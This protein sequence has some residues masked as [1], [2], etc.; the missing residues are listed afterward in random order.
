[1]S[2]LRTIILGAAVIAVLPTD[3]AKQERLQQTVA[4]AA[5]WS[6]T[7]CD[8]NAKTCEQAASTWETFKQKAQ[9]AGEVVIDLAMKQAL[10]AGTAISASN[11]TSTGSV[12]VADG[13]IARPAPAAGA[14]LRTAVSLQAPR[15]TLTARDLEPDWRGTLSRKAP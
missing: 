11:T 1:M 4:D 15:G 14:P 13:V 6:M 12:T 7:F 2:L 9:F 5:H 8:R 10:N 3:P